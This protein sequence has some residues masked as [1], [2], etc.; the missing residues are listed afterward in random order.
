MSHAN[1]SGGVNL[2]STVTCRSWFPRRLRPLLLLG[3]LLAA[4][5]CSGDDEGPG[6]SPADGAADDVVATLSATSGELE[7]S[8]AIP[9]GALPDGTSPSE[10]TIAAL[11]PDEVGADPENAEILGAYRF[12][13]D[14]L[15]FDVPLLATIEVGDSQ[16]VFALL[17]SSDGSSTERLQPVSGTFPT[18]EGTRTLVYAIDHFSDFSLV[19]SK[20]GD[21]SRAMVLDPLPRT[22]YLIGESFTIRVRIN[23]G[24]SN[25]SHTIVEDGVTVVR[26]QHRT[27]RDKPWYARVVWTV[28]QG[29]NDL[30]Q[31]LADL[32]SFDFDD[33]PPPADV[34]LEPRRVEGRVDGPNTFTAAFAEQTFTCR[35]VGPYEI[36]IWIG[37]RT[38][39]EQAS[40]GRASEYEQKMG[41][42]FTRTSD[43]EYY[44]P[45]GRCVAPAVETPIVD[46][47][48]ELST[49]EPTTEPTADP[50]SQPSP[51]A[52]AA[53]TTETPPEGSEA[54][55][56]SFGDAVPEDH[57][58]VFLLDGVFFLPGGLQVVA[59][60]VPFCSYEHLH[61][62]T[63]S[64][65][66]PGSNG[67]PVTRSEHLGECGFGPPNFFIVIDPRPD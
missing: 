62:G 54:R 50:T 39:A 24:F 3:L 41:P 31:T 66:L 59:A 19:L 43:G 8:L 4:T 53:P 56:A 37:V 32:L 25:W 49:V 23:P 10:L 55:P 44:R 11:G 63:I 42:W 34:P 28:S 26:E 47:T 48:S 51:V 7:L 61:G 27:L 5:A 45:G 16:S 15:E 13:P 17:T 20:E 35:K 58:L 9:V 57:V 1:V 2:R 40:S 46:P 22:T 38:R 60:H 30:V 64:S 36:S 12:G 33:P 6:A 67:D 52:S 21:G 29:S 18:D 65:L 14:G